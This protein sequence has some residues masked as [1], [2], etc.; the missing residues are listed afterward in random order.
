M[1]SLGFFFFWR[2]FLGFVSFFFP[3]E[4]SCCGKRFCFCF[5]CETPDRV[6][7]SLAAEK[8]L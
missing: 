5:F 7:I 2:A 4:N 6:I 8:G 1:V 3:S